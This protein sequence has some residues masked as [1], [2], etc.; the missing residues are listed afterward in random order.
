MNARD[1]FLRTA[2]FRPVD[3][4]FLLQPW[5]WGSTLQRWRK[6]GLP[7]EADMV[8]FFGT[9]REDYAPVAMQGPY[10]PHLVP[11]LERTILHET[12][13]YQVIRDEEGNTVRLFRADPDQSMPFWIAYPM[14]DRHD[15][16]TTIKPR[17]DPGAPGRYPMGQAFEAYVRSVQDRNSPLGIAVGSLYGWPR[18]F[19]GVEGLSLMFYDDPG[20]IHEMCQHIADFV[21]E[22]V[23]PFLERIQFDWAFYWEDMACRSGPLCSPA[24]Y[25][26]FMLPHL[27]RIVATVHAHG[28][29][30]IVVDSDGNNDALIPLWIEAGI[31]GWRPCEIA[32]GCDPVALRRRYGQSLVIQG[33]IDKRALARGRAAIDREVL[34]KVPWLCLQGGFFP[35]VDHLVP[36]DVSLEN[37]TYYA[38]LLRTVADDP[39]RYLHEAKRRGFWDDR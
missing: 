37:Y 4:P 11:P 25:R 23:T 21:I 28:V 39:E 12:G 2:G 24:T 30:H 19:L 20:L 17:L 3:R 34:S 6:E 32:A 22:A 5:L 16:E 29:P 38:R 31:D 35:Q 1:R 7:D 27:K 8:G 26:R 18:S 9:D 33:G 14:Q 10:G 15:W 36:P 13:Q